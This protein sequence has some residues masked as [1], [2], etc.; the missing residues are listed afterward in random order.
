[1]TDQTPQA[2][3]GF[4]DGNPK[5]LFAF[6][7]VSGIALTLVL[8]NFGGIALAAP[9]N[10]K[11]PVAKVAVTNPTTNTGGAEP[12]GELAAATKEDHV[13]GDLK[14]AKVVGIE[15]YDFEC[16]FCSRHHP[17][18]EQ[19]AAE[20]GDQIAWVYRHFP[21]SFHP[22]AVPAANASECA[23][24]QG[25]FWEYADALFANQTSLATGYYNTLAGELGLNQSKFDDCLA[26]NKY[27]AVIDAQTASGAAA[28]VNGTPA[29]FING[30]LVSGAVP[31]ASL[32][33]I[34]DA[35][36]AK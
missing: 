16:P 32:K 27:Q 6:G 33:Q 34:V 26:S 22:E 36:L 9:G 5:M 3:K 24:E 19:L 8:N 4:F 25:K 20:Y 18:M 21:L 31:Y 12:A 1:M 17:T 29:T 11:A 10:N 28:G 14:K 30:Q 2:P 35:E 15:Y 23:N 7:L 13:R